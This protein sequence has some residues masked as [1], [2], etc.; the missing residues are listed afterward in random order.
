MYGIQTSLNQNLVGA[1][2]GMF[3]LFNLLPLV[4]MSRGYVRYYYYS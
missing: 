3:A 1:M 4:G 2:I